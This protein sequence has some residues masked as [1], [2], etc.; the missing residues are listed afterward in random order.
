MVSSYSQTSPAHTSK[1]F[2]L[3][4]HVSSSSTLSL[5]RSHSESS[6]SGW[7]WSVPVESFQGLILAGTNST[8]CQSNFSKTVA[9]TANITEDGCSPSRGQ[10]CCYKGVFSFRDCISQPLLHLEGDYMTSFHQ[11]GNDGTNIF[12]FCVVMVK[13]E[14]CILHGLF[15]PP[16]AERRDPGRGKRSR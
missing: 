16:P 5:P 15:N 12:H 6:S 10:S 4:L 7:L 13:K 8:S 9:E 14:A 3:T 11:Q 2:L 1:I